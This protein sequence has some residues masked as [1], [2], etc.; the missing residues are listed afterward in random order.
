MSF[1]L[2]HHLQE[3]LHEIIGSFEGW[4]GLA[5][6]YQ[7]LFCTVRSLMPNRRA[8]SLGVNPCESSSITCSERALR[9]ARRV[10][11]FLHLSRLF[12][13]PFL[14]GDDWLTALVLSRYFHFPGCCDFGLTAREK[15]L[16]CFRQVLTHMKEIGHFS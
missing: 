8:I 15:E 10:K 2:A 7:I 1:S 16:C 14:D 11:R 4:A 6:H 3:I 5:K 9:P 12:G 13:M